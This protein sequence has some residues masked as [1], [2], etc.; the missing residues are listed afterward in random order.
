MTICVHLYFYATSYFWFSVDQPSFL[1]LVPLF[2]KQTFAVC[3]RGFFT[4]S[5]NIPV[6]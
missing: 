1:V 3:E 4:A 5:D 6:S 2:Q